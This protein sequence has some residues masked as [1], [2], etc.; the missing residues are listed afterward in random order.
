M[1]VQPRLDA[2]HQLRWACQGRLEQLVQDR[3]PRRSH[4]LYA[5]AGQRRACL[6]RTAEN[7]RDAGWPLAGSHCPRSALT[8]A[9]VNRGLPCSSTS[10]RN[11]TTVRWRLLGVSGSHCVENWAVRTRKRGP[12]TSTRGGAGSSPGSTAS[13]AAIPAHDMRI[14]CD[15][16]SRQVGEGFNPPLP[17]FTATFSI[18]HDRL[19]C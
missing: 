12:S 18:R 19:S 11:Q 10:R 9:S 17:S 1:A 2:G 5:C 16:G 7:L 8:P 6:P 4:R 3:L 14:L 15:H 13:M